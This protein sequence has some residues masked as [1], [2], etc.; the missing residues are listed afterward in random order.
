[1]SFKEKMQK[2]YADSFMKKNGDRL[3]QVQG[4]IIS[5]KVEQKAVLWIFHKL[6]A[7]VLVKP[8]RSRNIVRC[9]YKRNRWF[10]KPEFMTLNQGNLVIVQGLK[11]TSGKKG[12][13][14]EF[15]QIMNIRNLSTKKDLVHID[16]NSGEVKTIKKVR[17][18]K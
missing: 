1:M 14:K 18:M 9:I 12:D 11:S 8:D 7:T 3:T 4:N 2:Y 13:K 15:I 10:K 17:R 16:G 6:T 5:V